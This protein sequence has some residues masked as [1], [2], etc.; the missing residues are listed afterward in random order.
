MFWHQQYLLHLAYIVEYFYV[1][2]FMKEIKEEK[3]EGKKEGWKKGRK[4]N[5]ARCVLFRLYY[6][7]NSILLVCFCQFQVENNKHIIEPSIRIILS[8]TD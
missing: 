3:K 8:E 2:I 1:L 6:A 7:A 5:T 4:E